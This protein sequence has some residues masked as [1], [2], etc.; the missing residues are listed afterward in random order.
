[1]STTGKELVVVNRAT[2][3]AIDLATATDEEIAQ[4]QVALEDARQQLADVGREANGELL[5]R[6]DRALSWT[7]RVG[8]FELKAPSPT[9]GTTDYPEAELEAALNELYDRGVID[10]TGAGA[11]LKRQLVVVF[12]V[13]ITQDLAGTR[14]RVA[15]TLG[16]ALTLAIAGVPVRLAEVKVSRR[17]VQSG[18][19]KLRKLEGAAEVLDGVKRTKPAGERR[20]TVRTLGSD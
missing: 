1:M 14:D 5:R 4:F 7:R 9:A 11:A 19:D 15:D 3:E 6:L 2:G 13:P 12:D 10:G 20:V 18:V 8:R 16:R 17:T